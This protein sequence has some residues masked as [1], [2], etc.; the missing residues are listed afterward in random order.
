MTTRLKYLW[1]QRFGTRCY[2]LDCHHFET[3]T[4]LVITDAGVFSQLTESMPAE[5][6]LVERFLCCDV[7][8]LSKVAEEELVIT[9]VEALAAI[10]EI[11]FCEFLRVA[12]EYEVFTGDP[13]GVPTD[14]GLE[15]YSSSFK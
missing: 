10:M 3:P 9:T 15:P 8:V 11:F 4:V 5:L 6:E 1:R 14:V 13:C 2:P 12:A 7:E